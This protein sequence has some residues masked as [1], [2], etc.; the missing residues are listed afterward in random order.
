LS[1]RLSLLALGV[2]SVLEVRTFEAV[3]SL[4]VKLS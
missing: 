2:Y 4:P 1:Q 3:L